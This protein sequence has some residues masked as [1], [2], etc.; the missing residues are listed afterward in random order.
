MRRIGIE[1]S[2][3]TLREEIVRYLREHPND[4]EGFPLELFAGQGWAEYLA[5]MNK[6]GTY[7]DHITLQAASNIFNAQITV[8]SSLRV[9][10]T[11][12]I[13]P[14]T[15]VGVTNFN[16]GHFAEGQGE[17]Y[18][19]LEV[20]ENAAE[21]ISNGKQENQEVLNEDENKTEKAEEN[22]NKRENKTNGGANQEDI[23]ENPN[24]NDHQQRMSKKTR[25]ISSGLSLRAIVDARYLRCPSGR[26][27]S[28][29]AFRAPLG[30]W[31]SSMVFLCPPY[32]MLCCFNN[33]SGYE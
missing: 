7:G 16:L 20:E 4:L 13:S 32:T 21:N 31:P 3:E 8:H 1:R 9:E 33:V 23:Y 14:F 5:E 15:E 2:P 10:A 30:W 29:V 17:H 24:D 26:E 18:V 28:I 27:S 25:S 11:T 22:N 6:D 19:C 12:M